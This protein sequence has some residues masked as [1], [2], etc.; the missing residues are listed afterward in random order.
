MELL[1]GPSV[2]SVTN[3]SE[4]SWSFE[5]GLCYA[6]HFAVLGQNRDVESCEEVQRDN[7]VTA[8]AITIDLIWEPVV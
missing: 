2:F 6:E 4:T 8:K 3:A 7:L 1:R 5:Q